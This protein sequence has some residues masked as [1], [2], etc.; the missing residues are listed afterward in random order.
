M[1]IYWNQL[2]SIQGSLPDSL[3]IVRTVSEV[4]HRQP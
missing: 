3:S 4:S 1:N 2:L